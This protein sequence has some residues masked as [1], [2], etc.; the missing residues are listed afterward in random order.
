MQPNNNT[1]ASLSHGVYITV[2]QC[3][4]TWVHGKAPVGGLGDEVLEK[5]KQFADIVY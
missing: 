3:T 2:T 1:G 5:L 4:S